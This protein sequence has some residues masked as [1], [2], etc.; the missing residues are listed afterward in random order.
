[1]ALSKWYN[2]VKIKIITGKKGSGKTTY[3]K[4][5][6]NSYDGIIT[7]CDSRER[8]EYSFLLIERD[9]KISCC[10]FDKKMIF[11]SENFKIVNKYLQTIKSR[12]IIIDEIGWLELENKGLSSSLNYLLNRNIENLVLTMRF[13]SYKELIE[14][15]HIKDYELIIL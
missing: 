5:L 7:I 6:R 11:N 1:V 8:R 12:D 4:S 10:Y 13:D 2:Q 14:K 15:Y 9:K 3:L